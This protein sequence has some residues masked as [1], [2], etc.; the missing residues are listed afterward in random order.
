MTVTEAVRQA[1]DAVAA[2]Y[3]ASGGA[4]DRAVEHATEALFDGLADAHPWLLERYLRTIV[5]ALGA[6]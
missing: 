4:E 3:I 1:I 5:V 6:A 2:D